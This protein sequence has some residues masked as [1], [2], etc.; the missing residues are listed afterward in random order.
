MAKNWRSCKPACPYK[1]L[2]F[3]ADVNKW[4]CGKCGTMYDKDEVDKIKDNERTNGAKV[5]QVFE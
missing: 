5:T 1:K 3:L 2:K 4:S